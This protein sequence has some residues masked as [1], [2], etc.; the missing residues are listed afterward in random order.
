MQVL[1]D[2]KPS[3]QAARKLAREEYPKSV[4][5]AMFLATLMIYRV[6]LQHIRGPSNLSADYLSRIPPDRTNETRTI[7]S[8]VSYFATSVQQVSLT[9]ST[10]IGS[11][12][13]P[14][15]KLGAPLSWRMRT[16]YER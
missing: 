13:L 3:I 8:F 14:T 11:S 9:L 7:C 12:L 5:I 6:S 16:Y 10:A 15:L 1:T 4:R 2:S